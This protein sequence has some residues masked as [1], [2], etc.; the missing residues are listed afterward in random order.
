M[1]VNGEESRPTRKASEKLRVASE[2]RN[3]PSKRREKD[4]MSRYCWSVGLKCVVRRLERM[5]GRMLFR[6]AKMPNTVGSIC[7]H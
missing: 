2:E 1:Y 6:M 3:I 5:G 4:F 7:V